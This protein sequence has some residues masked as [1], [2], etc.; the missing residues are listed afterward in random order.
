MRVAGID[1]S[2]HAVDIVTVPLDEGQPF[3]HTFPPTIVTAPLSAGQPIWHRFPLTGRDAFDRA[4]SVADSVPG[5]HSVLWDDITAVGIEHPAGKF[6]TG[7]LLRIQGAI[8]CRLPARML[9]EPFPPAKWRKAVGLPGNA[10]KQAVS[11]FVAF[12]ATPKWTQALWL[13]DRLEGAS[14]STG[15]LWTQDARDAYCIA[16]ATRAAIT[17]EKAA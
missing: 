4:R 9:V 17:T 13:G 14:N 3:W 16:L 8:L 15:F 12:Q 2:S 6:G 7:A 11:D 5:R 1:Y 10:S